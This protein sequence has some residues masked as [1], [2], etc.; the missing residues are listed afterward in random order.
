MHK[1]NNF[2]SLVVI[3]INKESKMTRKQLNAIERRKRVQRNINIKR[4]IR[5]Y[6]NSPKRDKE[7][8]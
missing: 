7:N 1:L 6:N 2:V 4:D 5:R 8:N 3:E